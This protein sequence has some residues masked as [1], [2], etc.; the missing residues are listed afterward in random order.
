MAAPALQWGVE[1]DGSA[2]KRLSINPWIRK[3]LLLIY[4]EWKASWVWIT[5]RMNS[6]TLFHKIPYRIKPIFLPFLLQF[7]SP[8]DLF[9]SAVDILF[10]QL[11]LSIPNLFSVFRTQPVL[12]HQLFFPVSIIFSS[13][14]DLVANQLQ[15]KNVSQRTVT[16]IQIGVKYKLQTV[17]NRT[18]HTT[19]Q[20]RGKLWKP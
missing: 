17:W 14:H 8:P 20:T 4:M 3:L 11:N 6:R 18:F 2:S 1:R 13:C 19:A 16:T 10:H 5:I 12:V 7:L 9:C 15:L